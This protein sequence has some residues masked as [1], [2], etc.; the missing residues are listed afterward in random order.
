M[1]GELP[2]GVRLGAFAVVMLA[3]FGAAYGVGAAAA[4]DR[5]GQTGSPTVPPPGD[6][7]HAEGHRLAP[8]ESAP[9]PGLAVSQ[10]GHTFRPA[11]T[12][13][14]AGPSEPFTFTV[15]GPDGAPVA[16]YEPSHERDLHLVVVRR[17]LSTYEHVHPERAADGS[18]TTDLDLSAPGVYRAFADF[19]PQG[20]EPLTL[21]TDL[22]VPGEFEPAPLPAPTGR[23][24]VDDYEVTLTGD[25]R[26]GE[27]SDLVF[28]VTRDGAPVQ[29]LE[30]YL[31]A[32]G[33]LVALRA[34]DLAYLHTH[35][36]EAATTG[37]TG[38]PEVAFGTTFPTAGT[39]R[40]FLDF[41]VDGEVRTAP[42]TLVVPDAPGGT[43]PATAPTTHDATPHG[44]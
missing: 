41:Q 25:P 29:D 8:A 32:F 19:T 22:F 12:T 14:D 30:P 28:T 38:G 9:L 40:V 20:G 17:D 7:G 2:A 39:Y 18:W 4:P 24:V 10:A 42:F 11:T 13:L 3:A 1:N 37:D 36:G 33:H 26:L 15:T 31:G 35:P 5:T 27:R 44:H 43:G 23:S 6:A 16:D 21:G 34:G